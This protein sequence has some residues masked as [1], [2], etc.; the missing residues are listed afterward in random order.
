MEQPSVYCNTNI[1]YHIM[2]QYS[3]LAPEF[4]RSLKE[5]HSRPLACSL[6]LGQMHEISAYLSHSIS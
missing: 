5:K 6:Q 1:S 2:Y 3:G 4:D